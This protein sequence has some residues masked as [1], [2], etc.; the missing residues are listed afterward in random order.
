MDTI[1]FLEYL[2]GHEAT[3][4]LAEELAEILVARRRRPAGAMPAARAS[5]RAG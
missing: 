2:H 3:R 1:S 5:R 4:S